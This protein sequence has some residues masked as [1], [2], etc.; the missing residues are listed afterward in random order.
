MSLNYDILH[1]LASLDR[2]SDAG[3]GLRLIYPPAGERAELLVAVRPDEYS[4]TAIARAVEDCDVHLVNL[5][6]TSART[7]DGWLVVAVRVDCATADAVVRSL[8]RYGYRII[9]SNGT[10]ASI[11]DEESRRRAAELLYLL[12]I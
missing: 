9:A 2:D 12:Q 8:E 3:D 6:L 7:D 11:D 1:K 10:A 5:N 4:A